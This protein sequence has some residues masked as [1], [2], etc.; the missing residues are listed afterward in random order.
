MN[1]MHPPGPP[2]SGRRGEETSPLT[3][4]L[5]VSAIAAAIIII[6]TFIVA[7]TSTHTSQAVL[8][9]QQDYS[10]YSSAVVQGL[11]T[12]VTVQYSDIANT[13]CTPG[14]DFQRPVMLVLRFT[15]NLVPDSCSFFVDGSLVTTQRNL[16]AECRGSCPFTDFDREFS[17][18]DLDYRDSH[19]VRVCCDAIC[20]E[21]TLPSACS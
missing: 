20:I 10:V 21:K 5:I 14:S 13:S 11:Y 8:Q 17:L 12:F 18:G 16:D 9:Q 19:Q 15:P 2:A 3:M 1:D 6:I 7:A 4:F